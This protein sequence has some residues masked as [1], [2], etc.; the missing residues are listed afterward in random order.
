MNLTEEEFEQAI[1]EIKQ[2]VGEMIHGKNLGAVNIAL[3]ELLFDDVETEEDFK[4]LIE[5]LNDLSYAVAE[6]GF[7]EAAKERLH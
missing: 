1:D 3:A 7:G 6:G 5:I 2:E 4:Y